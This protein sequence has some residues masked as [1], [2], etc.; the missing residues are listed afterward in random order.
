MSVRQLGGRPRRSLSW[1]GI[2]AIFGGLTLIWLYFAHP[3]LTNS[4]NIIYPLMYLGAGGAMIAWGMR[5]LSDELWSVF[6][7]LR[8]RA[9]NQYR[10]RMPRE[11]VIYGLILL[12]LCAGALLGG[13]NMLMLV[14]GLMAGPFVLNGQVT[15]GILRRLSV[16]RRLPAHA[17]VGESFRVKLTLTNRKWLLSSWMVSVEDAVQ[18]P[19]EH[20]LPVVLFACV[21]PGSTR[22]AFFEIC[23]A[24]RGIYEFGP[25]RVISRFPLGLMERSIELGEIQ[26]LTVYPRIGRML[27]HWRDSVETGEPVCD[28]AWAASGINNDEFHS[29]REYR[30]GDNSR[31]IHWRTTARRNELMVRE[32][33]HSRRHDLLLVVELKLPARPDPADYE[34]VELAVSFA[35]SICV[36]HLQHTSEASIDLIV[37]G[38]ETFRG[39]GWTG[40]AALGEILD[41]L[42]VVEGG[43]ADGLTAAARAAA[44]EDCYRSRK[45]LI[46]S[47]PA[48]KTTGGTGENGDL[49]HELAAEQFEV[50]EAEAENVLRFLEYGEK[51]PGGAG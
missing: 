50:F 22:E 21:P 2:A 24:R 36:D 5:S 30:G 46:T 8:K 48:S 37:C 13:S 44:A 11:A 19:R 32:Y 1:I 41:R 49:R 29:L 51:G 3:F 31:A 12:V 7:R 38:R 16:A 23:A 28:S 27:P 4:T 9:A 43:A 14:F 6:R 10:V 15:L 34:R 18:S 35:S 47:R 39:S 17:T 20:L 26:T 45:L 40:S 25:M 33:Q 42:A